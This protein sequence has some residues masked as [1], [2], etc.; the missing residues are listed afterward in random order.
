[1]YSRTSTRQAAVFESRRGGNGLF[2]RK[3][4][5]GCAKDAE[6]AEG[7]VV[8]HTK[9][10]QTCRRHNVG[11]PAPRLPPLRPLRKL[12]VLCGEKGRYQGRL[13]TI[14]RLLYKPQQRCAI[15]LS[16]SFAIRTR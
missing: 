14:A 10:R 1:L 3:G 11:P 6:G 16:C 5:Q 12:C 4:R 13:G 9:T 7:P 2:Y 8:P 15:R